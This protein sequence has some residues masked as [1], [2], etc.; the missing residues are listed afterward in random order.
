MVSSGTCTNE[1]IGEDL[2]ARSMVVNESGDLDWY[3]MLTVLW[4][5]IDTFIVWCRGKLARPLHV[6]CNTLL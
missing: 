6:R 5:L 1:L 2:C 3:F 4:S